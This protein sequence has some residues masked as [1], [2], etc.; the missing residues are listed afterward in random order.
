METAHAI[1]RMTQIPGIEYAPILDPR[2]QG[3]TFTLVLEEDS[4]WL[5]GCLQLRSYAFWLGR[6]AEEFAVE[7]DD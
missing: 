2:F 1:G 6:D 4:W 5:R 3:W 7:T